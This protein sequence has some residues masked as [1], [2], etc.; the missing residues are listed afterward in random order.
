[1]L[2]KQKI[3]L[4]SGALLLAAIIGIYAI[5]TLLA[6]PKLYKEAGELARA[7]V[8]D[9]VSEINV[10]LNSTST[11]TRSLA[12]LAETLPADRAL[13]QEHLDNVIDQYGNSA[14][15]GGGVWPE[16]RLLDADEDRASLF[17]GRNGARLDLLNDYNEASGSGYHNEGWYTVGRTLKPGQCAWS[18][19]YFDP[20]S[21]VAMTTCTVA[22]KRDNRFWGVA[23]VDLMLEGM[24]KLLKQQ[25]DIS[26]GVVMAVDQTGRIIGAPGLR[27]TPLA[28][29]TLNEAIAADPA[30]QT[31]AQALSKG[32]GIYPLPTGVIEGDSA[33][34][35]V[36]D[37]PAQGWRVGLIL[38]DSVALATLSDI[39]GGLYAVLI[40]LVLIFAA[41]LLYS[42]SQLI[43]W[44]DETTRQ[45]GDMSTG[46]AA[47]QLAVKQQDEIG[48]LRQA[49]NQYGEHLRNLL[50]EL[51]RESVGVK[52]GAES[53]QAL[54]QTLTQ[55][56]QQQTDEHQTLAAA[57]T[58]MSASAQE[59]S[60][61]TSNAAQTAEEAGTLV[62]E[63]RNVVTSNASAISELADALSSAA[64]VIDQLAG[65]TQRV[66]AVLDVI[67]AISEQTNLLALN[68]AIEAAR[69][70]EQGRGFAVVADE[71]RTL[72]GRTQESASEI[73]SM[74][75]Q[76]QSA[77]KQGVT[78]ISS[79]RDLS[80]QSIE[81][82]NM[83]RSHFDA[84]V[85]AFTEIRARTNSIATAA[86]EQ[87]RVTQEIT[88]LADRIQHI[89]EQNSDDARKLQSMSQTST[90]LAQRLH[91]ISQG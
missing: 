20:A 52:E 83:A 64:Q 46:R 41:A 4:A 57:I 63:G 86:G 49:V 59:V 22:I 36:A 19:V 91:Q 70:G 53:L 13:L 34:L 67:K 21:G 72:A 87:A 90:Q 23:T 30:L 24:G 6:E 68:A 51:G 18:E 38:P 76:L 55:R 28:T 89:S 80:A 1:M 3:R 47:Q 58:Q 78:V 15:A 7:Q 29:K 32:E 11:L 26:G 88:Q 60:N 45:I 50:D 73:E 44:L 9:T 81:R 2:L 25:S 82:A 42:G 61:N 8:Q 85:Q 69:A 12:L 54:S 79:S 10:V 35:V 17:W 5:T 16:P 14:I 62:N 31:L 39:T 77:A 43:A 65:D 66:G 56:A 71:V 37:M 84:I 33:Q 74:I 75:A 40:P 48:L 27:P